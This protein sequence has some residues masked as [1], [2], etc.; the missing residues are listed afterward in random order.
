M[1][2]VID[3][4]QNILIGYNPKNETSRDILRKVEDSGILVNDFSVSGASLETVFLSIT[5]KN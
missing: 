4:D 1:G 2:A 3:K 5:S